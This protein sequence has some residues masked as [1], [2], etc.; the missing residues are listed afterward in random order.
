MCEN[1][2]KALKNLKKVLSQ[3]KFKYHIF[4]FTAK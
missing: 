2:Q 3:K 1:K 4:Q